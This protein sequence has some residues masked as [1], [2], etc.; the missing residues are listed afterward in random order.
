MRRALVL[1]LALLATPA[2]AGPRP[3]GFGGGGV[4]TPVISGTPTVGQTLSVPSY[5]GATYQ[6]LRGGSVISGATSNT[7]TTVSG[8][9][10]NTISVRI[11]LNG[12]SVVLSLGISG[13][14]ITTATRGSAYAGWTASATGGTAPYSYSIASGAYPS[15]ISLNSSTGASSGTPTVSGTFAGIVVRVTDAVANHSDL[16][17]FTLTVSLPP[18]G[19]QADFS[20]AANSG[21]LTI[22]R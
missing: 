22:I 15:G 12:V 10:G 16:G 5:A 19:G 4:S 20:K 18:T 6:W 1:A 21:L 3:A 11:T 17:S 13:T 9:A 8:D 14:P 7:Y 2:L